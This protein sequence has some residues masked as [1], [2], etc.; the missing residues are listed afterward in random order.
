MKSKL[1]IFTVVNTET[2]QKINISL[3]LTYRFTFLLNRIIILT[4]IFYNVVAC[5]FIGQNYHKNVNYL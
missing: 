1:V 4:R 5:R 2:K 3:I